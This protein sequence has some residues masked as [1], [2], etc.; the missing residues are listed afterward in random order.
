[1]DL[2]KLTYSKSD[3]RRVIRKSIIKPHTKN[4]VED[5]GFKDLK[6]L[7]AYSKA[8]G[9]LS[10]NL[11][12]V[13]SGGEKRE[14]DFLRELIRQR[15]LHSLRVAFMS[16]KGQGMQPYQ[17]QAKWKEIKSVGVF[18]IDSRIYHL[19][20][21]DKVFLLS[22]VDEFHQQLADIFKDKSDNEQG[23]WIVSNP[24]FEIWLY[25]CY[26][27]DPESDLVSLVPERAA[28]RSKKLKTLCGTL[29]PGGM[30]PCLAFERMT[31][32]IENSR[33]HYLVDENGIPV[34]FATGMYEMAR[35]LV[36]TMNHNANEYTEYVRRKEEWRMA[37]KGRGK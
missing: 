19:E 2:A 35:Y 16:E 18:M 31:T 36:D 27:N 22:D 33:A 14:K 3:L 6:V 20:A 24:C 26:L 15:E 1:M 25:Y 23:Q 21:A 10:T 7:P 32:G 4:E 30:N 11:V 34:L 12:F 37:M 13:L 9:T 8:D 5:V 29:V 28:T 17:M